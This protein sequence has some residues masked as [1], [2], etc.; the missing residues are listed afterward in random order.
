MTAP[1]CVYKRYADRPT[2]SYYDNLQIRKIMDTESDLSWSK[3][4]KDQCLY[5]R[6]FDV[7]IDQ[8]ISFLP[9]IQ[10]HMH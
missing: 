1:L 5:Y 9:H 6:I 2:I 7:V 10:T 4:V 8:C 3:Q